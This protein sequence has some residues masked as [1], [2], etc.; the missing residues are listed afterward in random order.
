MVFWWFLSGFLVV[1]GVS[2][3]K[4]SFMRVFGL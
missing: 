1:F 2:E 3:V 4:K